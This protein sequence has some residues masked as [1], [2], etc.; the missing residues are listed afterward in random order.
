MTNLEVLSLAFSRRDWWKP[1]NTSWQS[2]H[3]RDW[4]RHLSHKSTRWM[5]VTGADSLQ[6]PSFFRL[7]HSKEACNTLRATFG[8]GCRPTVQPCHAWHGG[9]LSWRYGSFHRYTVQCIWTW[10]VPPASGGD[11]FQVPG[12]SDP[13]L[14][15]S[16]TTAV[17]SL[18]VNPIASF[19]TDACLIILLH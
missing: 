12:Q 16:T 9:I 10:W 17:I 2:V 7:R 3:L 15:L 19:T 5:A 11:G 8:R 4:N 18:K 1:R 6:R 13:P 14:Y